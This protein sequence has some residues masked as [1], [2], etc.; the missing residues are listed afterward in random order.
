MNMRPGPSAFARPDC[1]TQP[2]STCSRGTNPGRTHR[3]YDGKPVVP[4]G[5]GLSY[6]SWSYAVEKQPT[7]VSLAPLTQLLNETAGEGHLFP[8]AER[9][10]Q[11]ENA[12]KWHASAAFTI[13]VTNTGA[14]DADDV[15]LGFLTPPGAGQGGVPLQILFAFERVFVKAGA[16][17]MVTMAPSLTDFAQA[18]LDGTLKTAAG[19]YSAH[20]GVN[21]TAVHGMGYVVAGGITAADDTA[22]AAVDVQE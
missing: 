19:S 16:T 10:S 20:F 22:A 7:A 1:H 15:I 12:S 5:F 3:F 9:V 18:Q 21:E 4:F 6:T 17:V 2:A 14:R 11:I 8:K 13:N